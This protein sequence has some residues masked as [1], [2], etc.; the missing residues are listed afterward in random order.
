[1]G[2]IATPP[3]GRGGTRGASGSP[4]NLSARLPGPDHVTQGPQTAGLVLCPAIAVQGGLYR[5]HAFQHAAH[6]S[7]PGAVNAPQGGGGSPNARPRPLEGVSDA[8]RRRA[9]RRAHRPVRPDPARRAQRMGQSK[10]PGG[11][12]TAPRALVGRL[13]GPERVHSPER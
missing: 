7:G 11:G 9:T 1:M 10:G 5:V 4:P 3:K 2:F 13:R 8:G 12:S 6:S